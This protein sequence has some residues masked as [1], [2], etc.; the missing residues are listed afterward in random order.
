[1]K[2]VFF[3]SDDFAA[4]HLEYLLDSEDEVV[5]CVTQ[6]DKPKGRGMSV[7][8]SPI[9]EIAQSHN[10]P[11]LQPLNVNE[12]SVINELSLFNADIF[13]VVA[14]GRILSKVVLDIPN[15][16]A[17]N[18]HSSLLP[19][20]RGA[21]PINW[22]I[23]NDDEETGVSIIKMNEKMDQG[24][25]IAAEKVTIGNQDTAL[26]IRKR[27]MQLGPKL[28]LETIHAIKEDSVDFITQDER[29]AT[30]APKLTKELGRIDWNKQAIEIHNLVRGLLPWPTAHTS[31][32]GKTLK[33]LSSEII[34]LKKDLYPQAG[35]VNNDDLK[36]K[37]N[38]TPGKIKEITKE[39]FIIATG[40]SDLLVKEVHLESSKPISAI[41]FINGQRINVGEALG[42]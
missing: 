4:S 18:V 30:F 42:T 6:P 23:I 24:E 11:V 16:Y 7:S 27:M 37:I 20:Y 28:L 19:A 40:R 41:E 10:I 33:I 31:F 39:G 35:T 17:I 13:I 3:G 21:A 25:I 22:A 9:K 36:T 2:I 14:Y 15:T 5:A 8:A 29:L 12:A 32:K 34:S 1:M 26:D 38:G